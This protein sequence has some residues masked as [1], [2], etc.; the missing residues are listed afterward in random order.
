MRFVMRKQAQAAANLLV[1]SLEQASKGNQK[2]KDFFGKYGI[3][4][5]TLQEVQAQYNSHGW[6][7]DKWDAGGYGKVRSPLTTIIDEDVL[8][9]RTEEAPA[10]AQY[11]C[12]GGA[13]FNYRNINIISHNSI[14]SR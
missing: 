5:A 7:L 1:H 3:D 13:M 6:S 14:L 12:E 9:A 10:L 4:D 11:N 2:L 8:R